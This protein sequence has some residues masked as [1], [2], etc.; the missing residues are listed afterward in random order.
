MFHSF[1]LICALASDGNPVE[2]CT[3]IGDTRGP[4]VS[5]N[6]CQARGEEIA[7]A[8][9]N[10]PDFK[11]MIGIQLGFPDNIAYKAICY[12]DGKTMI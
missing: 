3:Q 12:D 2:P 8:V 6:T 7:Q 4:Y 1:L 9:L 5:F 10:D 11:T